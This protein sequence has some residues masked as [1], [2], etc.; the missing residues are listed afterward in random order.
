MKGIFF[1]TAYHLRIVEKLST[2]QCY[3]F[4]T[5]ECLKIQTISGQSDF[6]VGVILFFLD[7]PPNALT[8]IDNQPRFNNQQAKQS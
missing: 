6:H 3:R 1:K 2:M 4:F 8:R 5:E 7:L